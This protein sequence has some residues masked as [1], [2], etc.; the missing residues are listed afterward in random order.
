VSQ[1]HAQEEAGE[2]AGAGLPQ[3]MQEED[4][5]RFSMEHLTHS[6]MDILEQS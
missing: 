5:S 6:H 4:V 3:E 2:G 1:A